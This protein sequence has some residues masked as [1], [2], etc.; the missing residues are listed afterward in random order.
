MLKLLGLTLAPLRRERFLVVLAAATILVSLFVSGDGGLS[1]V[2]VFLPCY[3]VEGYARAYDYRYGQDEFCLSL[4]VSRRDFVAARY[5]LV[6]VVTAGTLLVLALLGAAV[7]AAGAVSSGVPAIFAVRLIVVVALFTGIQLPLYFRFGYMKSRILPI[8]LFAGI[9]AVVGA[10]RSIPQLAAALDRSNPFA[11]ERPL[12]DL[13][14]LVLGAA[15]FTAVSLFISVR[16]F[17]RREF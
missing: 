13:A 17:R 1:F 7:R 11:A 4:P 14:L 5:L 3:M 10:L 12:G 8:V 16:A 15:C 6:W 9:G 2:L